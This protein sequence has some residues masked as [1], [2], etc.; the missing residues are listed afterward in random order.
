MPKAEIEPGFPAFQHVSGYDGARLPPRGTQY[1][2]QA[3]EKDDGPER[4][5][6]EGRHRPERK[7]P[8]REGDFPDPAGSSAG[9]GGS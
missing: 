4:R 9:R 2:R 1:F 6:P 7:E 5:R 3:L 8:G